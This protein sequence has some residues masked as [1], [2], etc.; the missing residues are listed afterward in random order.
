MRDAGEGVR[1]DAHGVLAMRAAI[2]GAVGVVHDVHGIMAVGDAGEHLG[3]D[4]GMLA[5]MLQVRY[6]YDVVHDVRSGCGEC[7]WRR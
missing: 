2:E 6:V 4:V 5:K 1:Y 3:Y 7:C